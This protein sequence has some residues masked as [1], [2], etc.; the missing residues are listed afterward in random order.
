VS[1]QTASLRSYSVL[2]VWHSSQ[3]REG[4]SGATPVSAWRQGRS[5]TR[6]LS[7]DELRI[8]LKDP[9][10]ATRFQR[11]AHAIT[12]LLLT[13]QRRGELALA[14]WTDV[15]LQKKI[16]RIPPEHS[17]NGREHAIPLSDWAVAL[18]HS[19]VRFG[20]R[21]IHIIFFVDRRR[22]VLLQSSY[23]F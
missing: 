14:R 7:D 17:K 19:R 13:A 1:W 18:A 3:D 6:T 4:I 5:R 9:K 15:D 12:I 16:W 20:Y 11:L 8:F 23:R 21:R 2:Q 10:A 22:E